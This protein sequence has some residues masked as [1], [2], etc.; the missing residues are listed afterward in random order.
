MTRVGRSVW[1]LLPHL[2]NELRD[3]R[4]KIIVSWFY[5]LVTFLAGHRGPHEDSSWAGCGPRAGRCAPLF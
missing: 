1:W 3:V 2:Y 4:L 5:M